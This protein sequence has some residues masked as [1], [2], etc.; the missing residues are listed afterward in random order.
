M[1]HVKSIIVG[2]GV[3]SNTV[4]MV[5]TLWVGGGREHMPSSPHIIWNS[6]K[7]DFKMR[8]ELSLCI[9]KV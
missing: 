9:G 1:R 7:L 2:G 3:K 5:N 6:P 4:L 8:L